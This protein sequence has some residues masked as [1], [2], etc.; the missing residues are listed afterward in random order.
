M[1]PENSESIPRKRGG[2]P[3]NLNGLKH[4]LYIE[5]RSVRNTTPVE[6]AVV[7]DLKQ[8]I[9]QTKDYVNTLYIEGQKC[10][11]I[12]EFNLTMHNIAA[13]GA[14]LT[15]LI[16]I[17]NQFQNSS[18]PSDFVVTKRTTVRN[19]VDHYKGKVSSITDISELENDL[20]QDNRVDS[21]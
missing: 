8:I 13:A 16:S 17:H 7:F 14:T 5:G 21:D 12:A 9:L 10:K 15:R 20:D 19:L 6:R 2:Q 11:N 18:L 4:G 1:M 3:G